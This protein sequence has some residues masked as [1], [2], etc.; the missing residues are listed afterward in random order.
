VPTAA[1]AA[2]AIAITPSQIPASD[3]PPDDD[4]EPVGVGE[5]VEPAAG[6]APALTTVV[7]DAGPC[8]VGPFSVA[9]VPGGS[10]RPVHGFTLPSA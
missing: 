9:T 3:D 2:T 7:A 6:A 5:V 4:V 1:A 8:C 10:G